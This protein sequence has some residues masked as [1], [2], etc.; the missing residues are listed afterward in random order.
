WD[1]LRFAQFLTRKKSLG[2][3]R[4]P[5]TIRLLLRTPGRQERF[6]ATKSTWAKPRDRMRFVPLPPSS[7]ATISKSWME[8][9]TRQDAC[10]VRTCT[11]SSITTHSDTVFLTGLVLLKAWRPFKKKNVCL[12]VLNVKRV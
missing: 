8:R 4:L 10:W 6:K 5:Y 11:V 9:L 1:C 12:P 3:L 7:P 2:R